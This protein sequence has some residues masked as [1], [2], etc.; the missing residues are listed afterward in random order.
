MNLKIRGN[1]PFINFI[2][3]QIFQINLKKLPYFLKINVP[4]H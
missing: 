4:M 2:L 3:K 1:V